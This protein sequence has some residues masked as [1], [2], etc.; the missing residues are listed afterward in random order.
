MSP[1]L[2]ERLRAVEVLEPRSAG[3]LLVFGLRWE[4]DGGLP[5]QTLDEALAAKT[6]DITEVNESGTV[7]L[8]K[9]ANRGDVAVF[10]MAGEQLIG[11]KQNRILNTSLLVPAATEMAVP[12]S[13]VEAGRWGY[14]SPKF[15]SEGTASHSLLRRMLAEQTHDSYKREGRATARQGEVWD[16][17]TRKLSSM[18]SPSRTA[19]LQQ[20]YDDHR[21]R[22]QEVQDALDVP[23]ACNGAAFARGPRVVGVDLFDRAATLTKLWPKVL[24]AYA[25]DALEQPAPAAATVNG[26]V[27]GDWLRAAADAECQSFKSPGMGDDL[28]IK[29]PGV[30]GGGLIVEDR[31]VHAEL[32][33]V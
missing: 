31:P 32:F 30:I 12:V 18:G 24:R 4:L 17:V 14:R 27:V 26:N 21:A 29:G 13:C 16:E 19:A 10:L 28:R 25:I 20:A 3:G 23:E 7:P 8:L 1:T 11:A 15:T 22:L 6:L 9:V 2:A 33:A 5:Y